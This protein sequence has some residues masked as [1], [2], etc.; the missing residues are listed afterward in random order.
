M[1][2]RQATNPD[3]QK[4]GIPLGVET[5]KLENSNMGSVVSLWLYNAATQIM[6]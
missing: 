6:I 4:M 2:Q 3:L 5:S 1:A